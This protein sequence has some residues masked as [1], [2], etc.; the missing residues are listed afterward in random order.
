VIAPAPAMT[1]VCTSALVMVCGVNA[2]AVARKMGMTGDG[3]PTYEASWATLMIAA[4]TEATTM[5]QT[6]FSEMAAAAI[7]TPQ[8]TASITTNPPSVSARRG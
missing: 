3:A 5:R 7:A 4:S 1:A 2:R 8:T 6:M